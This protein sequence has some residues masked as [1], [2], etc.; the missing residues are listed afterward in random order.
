[1]NPSGDFS[2]N[3]WVKAGASGDWQSSVT[4][5]SANTACGED[6][7]RTKGYM[8]Y[9]QADEEWSFWNGNCGDRTW[10]R[11]DTS[12]D[13]NL[14]TWQMQTVTYDASETMMKLYVD[15]VLIGNDNSNTL[16]ANDNEPLRIGAGATN[17]DTPKYWFNGK[18]DEVAI[19]S[20]TLSSDEIVQLYNSGETLYAGDNYGDYTLS[21]I[22]I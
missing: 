15:G 10:A 7:N 21:L 17:Q 12:V 5:R 19:W 6:A 9:I 18:I 20:S 14:N 3:V 13:V 4:S 8:V 1:M 22:H 11:L 2:V 16:T